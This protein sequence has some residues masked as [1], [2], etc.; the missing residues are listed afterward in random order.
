[1]NSSRA[2]KRGGP[3]RHNAEE[4]TEHDAAAWAL[5]TKANRVTAG[6]FFK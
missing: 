2:D 5:V 6:I 3:F 4:A 1:M